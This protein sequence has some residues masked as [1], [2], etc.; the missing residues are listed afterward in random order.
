LATLVLFLLGVGVDELV[1]APVLAVRRIVV[2]GGPGTLARLTGVRL[3]TPMLTVDVA[4]AARRVLARDPW[5]RWA[6]VVRRWPATLV[7]EVGAR[8]VVALVETDGGAVLGVDASGRLLP[9]ARGALSAYPYLGGV[10]APDRPYRSIGG[11]VAGAE[12]AVA[13]DLPAWLAPTTAEI[14]AGSGGLTLLLT[15]GTHVRLGTRS[16]LDQK[17]RVL[18]AILAR[19]GDRTVGL[20]DVSDP[21]A[22]T[23]AVSP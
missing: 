11:R 9:V 18:H 7:L 16:A 21:A 20:I 13:A 2:E 14:D 6:R 17:Y 12:L 3:G 23:V 4:A 1:R 10:T 22:P 15:S 5:L 8:Q 19:L